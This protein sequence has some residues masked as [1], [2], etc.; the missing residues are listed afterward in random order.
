MSE[1]D[2]T[3][4]EA[5]EGESRKEDFYE[6]QR[7]VSALRDRA[8]FVGGNYSTNLGQIETVA[9]ALDDLGMVPVVASEV[10]GTM[11]PDRIHEESLRLLHNCGYA[12]VEVTDPAGQLMELERARDYGVVTYAALRKPENHQSAMV[13]K[14][15]RR[16][17]GWDLGYQFTYRTDDQLERFVRSMFSVNHARV[18]GGDA[19]VVERLVGPGP[20]EVLLI[21]SL[22]VLNRASH[23][24]PDSLPGSST[25]VMTGWDWRYARAKIAASDAPPPDWLVCEGCVVY[26]RRDGDYETDDARTETDT[27]LLTDVKRANRWVVEAANETTGE[28]WGPAGD[29]PVF[30]SQGNERSVAYYVNPPD[31]DGDALA[32]ERKA[33]TGGKPLNGTRATIDEM[34]RSAYDV[35]QRDETTVQFPG[36][37]DEPVP[38]V[39]DPSTLEDFLYEVEKVCARNRPFWPY[40]VDLAAEGVT[41]DLQPDLEYDAFTSGDVERVVERARELAREEAGVELPRRRIAAQDDVCIDIFYRTKDEVLPEVLD[42]FADEDTAVVYL[43]RGTESD[44]PVLFGGYASNYDFVAVGTDHVSDTLRNAGVVPL[45]QSTAEVLRRVSDILS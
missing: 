19:D 28:R 26:E 42:Q 30:L 39:V 24:V 29:P 32:D 23:G 35:V 12:V 37:V 25:V 10:G 4:E 8:V 40:S 22:G 1:L 3:G 20:R 38:D 16:L 41:V 33:V 18:D 17:E 36:S 6:A 15:M 11:D 9:D 5:T 2:E 43:S 13:G 31:E 21:T 27:A 34:K 44:L 45:G 7:T 14:L